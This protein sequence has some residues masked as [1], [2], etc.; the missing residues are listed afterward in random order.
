MYSSIDVNVK[1]KRLDRENY[2]MEKERF[3]HYTCLCCFI[4]PVEYHRPLLFKKS[5][6]ITR[7]CSKEQPYGKF[8]FFLL[9]QSYDRWLALKCPQMLFGRGC[10]LFCFVFIFF[11]LFWMKSGSFLEYWSV[12]LLTLESMRV[13]RIQR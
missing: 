3:P 6:Q 7:S 8:E 10:S 12:C 9:I 4:K 11:G 13:E 1:I 5:C 2:I